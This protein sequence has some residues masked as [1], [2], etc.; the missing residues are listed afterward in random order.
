MGPM[1]LPE[2]G[3]LVCGSPLEYAP[4]ARSVTCALC[5]ASAQSE[6]ACTR[7]HFVCDACHRAPALDVIE[8][9]CACS[10]SLD[11][12]AMAQA[13]MRAPS[14]KMHGPEHHYLVPAVLLSAMLEAKGRREAKPGA[15]KEARRRAEMVPGG[16]CGTH[17]NCGAAVGTGIFASVAFGATPLATQSWGWANELTARSLLRIATQGGPRCC[18][19]DTF[20]ALTE[21][22]AFLG[23]KTG[24]QLACPESITC[25]FFERNR[26]CIRERCPFFPGGK[27]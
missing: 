16:Y 18:K 5:G 22:V 7:G 8:R 23:E 3:C 2:S 12:V 21:A 6:A 13:I 4:A 9:T 17:G 15:L 19:R 24:I 11:P 10:T 20:L 27:G 26:E 25:E 14:V 1:T